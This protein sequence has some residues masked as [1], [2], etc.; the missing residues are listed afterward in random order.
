M[1]SVVTVFPGAAPNDA[2][3]LISIPIEK[4]LR[5]VSGIDKVRS[6]NVEN[7]SFLVIYLDDRAKDKK[8]IVQD[9]KDAVEQVEGLPA[10]AQKPL[11]TEINFD[12]TELVSVAFV[13]KTKDVPYARLREFATSPKTFSTIS[14]ESPR[15]KNWGT[16]TGI[17]GGS[18]S[19][20]PHKIPDRDEHPHQH[21]QDE[22][23]RFPG[24]CAPCG[25]KGIRAPNQGQFKN[26]DEIRNTVIMAN[27]GGYVT[28]IGDIAKV[29]DTYEEADVHHRFNGKQAVVFKLW[30][31]R[32][33]DE[34]DLSNRL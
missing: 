18:R 4:K 32:S 3:E 11:V 7:V 15:S 23:R 26:V 25:K 12:N 17:P 22:K 28:R 13:G 14:T 2:E 16:M 24:R 9:I 34:I 29:S 33:A 8:K 6:Y 20:R 27:D 30:K 10:S 1:V 21:S 31:K 5:G 19:G